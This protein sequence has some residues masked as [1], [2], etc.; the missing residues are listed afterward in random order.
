MVPLA[1][2]PSSI[3]SIQAIDARPRLRN[4]RLQLR[5][6]IFPKVDESTVILGRVLRVACALVQ[7]TKA[8]QRRREIVAIDARVIGAAHLDVLA[9]IRARRI[10]AAATIEGESEKERRANGAAAAR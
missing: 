5:I 3:R 4:A 7:L 6:G 8:K 9:Q 1:D 2:S 10:G